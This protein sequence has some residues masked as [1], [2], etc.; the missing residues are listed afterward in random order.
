VNGKKKVVGKYVSQKGMVKGKDN[1]MECSRSRRGLHSQAVQ[2][3]SLMGCAISC[4]VG[5]C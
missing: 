4:A 3:R 1:L 2:A 5:L